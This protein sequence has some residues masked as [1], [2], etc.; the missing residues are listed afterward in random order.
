MRVGQAD[1]DRLEGVIA[2]LRA[3]DY[4]EGG[5]ACREL[6][7][8]LEP[9]GA[10]LR[11]GIMS[12]ALSRRLAG[13]VADLH[14][15]V[16]WTE[17]DTGRPVRAERHF[18]R[19]LELAAEAGNDDLVANIHYRLGRLYLHHRSPADALGQFGQGQLAARRAGT[20]LSQAILSA[21]EAW[22]YAL[23]GDV[24][25]ALDKISLAPEQFASSPTDAVPSWSA[26]F[27]AN[28]MAAMIGTVRTELA[29]LV[30]VAH[31]REAIPALT[32]AI[33]GYG[34]DMARSRSLTMIWLA[35]DHALEGDL[36]R[37][38]AVGLAA[39]EIAGGIRSAR[40][41]DRLRP[42]SECVRKRMADINARD[43]LDRIETFRASA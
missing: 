37:A 11:R 32:E 43:L 36:D 33:E 10:A 15:L 28:D 22:A 14:N 1:V 8:V 21:N 39:M 18:H 42:L 20:P 24:R 30:D 3:R 9:Y 41:R 5:G 16:G 34:P 23:L 7:R 6:L 2:A 35:V 17:F 40:T 26:F 25:Q 38:A 31:S 12:A 29:R 19:A 27:T 13:V 4:R